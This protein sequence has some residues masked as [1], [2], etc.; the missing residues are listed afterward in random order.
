MARS[1][2]GTVRSAELNSHGRSVVA[3]FA[4]HNR[5]PRP[6]PTNCIPADNPDGAIAQNPN[7]LSCCIQCG[8]NGIG[9][10]EKVIHFGQ[11]IRWNR[12]NSGKT[13]D[14]FGHEIG[15]TARRVIAIEAM[16]TPDVQHTTLVALARALG[17]EPENFDKVWRSTPVS[18]T[19][20]KT[21]PTTDESRRFAIACSTARIL[22]A[23]GMR[24]LRSWLVAQD[25]ATQ[26]QVLSFDRSAGSP[27]PPIFTDL[28]DHLQDP[29]ADVRR[30]ISRKAASS[31]KSAGSASASE[32]K[33]R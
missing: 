13:T 23:E 28:V 24:R 33:R 1:G 30:R 17:I 26:K 20:R 12:I 4:V 21:G 29:A 22:P 19:Q 11:F 10:S 6:P 31:A 16:A 27:P 2:D 5:R 14:V 3:D 9:V 15:L 7:D 32:N 18:V 8:Y 25:P